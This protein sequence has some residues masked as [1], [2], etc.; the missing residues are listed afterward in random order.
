M[1]IK[2]NM[3]YFALNTKKRI[4]KERGVDPESIESARF[5]NLVQSKLAE[6]TAA[7]KFYLLMACTR[8]LEMAALLTEHPTW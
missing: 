6:L 3:P 4:A 1:V 5:T 8:T 2:F 7:K